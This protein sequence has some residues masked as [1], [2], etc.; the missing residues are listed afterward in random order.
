M[1]SDDGAHLGVTAERALST[2]VGGA[3]QPSG[4]ERMDAATFIRYIESAPD[5]A[6]SYN[7]TARLAAKWLLRHLR[8]HPTDI[9]LPIDGRYECAIP[10]DWTTSRKVERD[11]YDAIKESCPSFDELG[12]TGFMWG[13]AANA[14]RRCLEAPPLPNPAIL[15][16][17]GADARP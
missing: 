4:D 13:W 10:G 2:I 8:D 17:G 11:L 12:L 5:D 7:D 6:A 16:V 15:D 1:Q 14:A 9:N 3:P